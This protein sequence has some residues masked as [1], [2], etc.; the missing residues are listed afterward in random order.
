MMVGRDFNLEGFDGGKVNIFIYP[1]VEVDDVESIVF[2]T[3]FSFR[4]L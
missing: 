2:I 1:I 4:N 3:N